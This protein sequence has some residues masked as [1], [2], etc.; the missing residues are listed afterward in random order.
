M[1]DFLVVGKGLMGAAAARYL[2][3]HSA[4]VA[5]M[6]PD[7]PVNHATHTGIFG[8]HY[9][10]AR[11]ISQ[12][13]NREL[14]WAALSHQ[15]VTQL[16]RLEVALGETIHRPVGCLSVLPAGFGA[17][18]LH[19]ADQLAAQFNASYTLLDG[20]QQRAALPML[21]FPAHAMALWEQAP[22]GYLNPRKLL[23]GQLA[24]AEQQQA[25]LIREIV[26]AVLDRGDHVEVR[27]EAGGS[28]QA[29]KVLIATGAFT[30][31]FN[32]FPK[33]LAL[34]TK[35]EFVVM[36]QVPR[37]EVERLQGMPAVSYQIEAENL[38]DLYLFPP[39]QYPDGNY[40]IKMGANTR[41]DRYVTTLDEINGWYRN[42]DSDEML[43]EMRT[44]LCAIVPGL[45]ATAWHTAR[46]VITRT[47]HAKPY[48]DVVV[49][50]RIYAAIGGNG[51]SAQ[52]SDGIGKVAAN[53][54]LH[55]AWHSPLEA[56][57]FRLVYAD[58]NAA[59]ANREL[60][61]GR[62]R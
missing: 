45:Q 4:Q 59:W 20:A 2:S 38:A 40:Y 16:P 37:E 43:A 48:I 1:Y 52:A 58:E 34:R 11:M 39:V 6:G 51:T 42:G 27:T 31:C 17:E 46:C 36:G 32:L 47:V 15:T 50:G 7:E 12:V 61:R 54:V 35:I 10:Q 60:A 57:A 26:T 8:A 9:D 23:A 3:E 56:N 22:A 13:I 44:A 29:R 62:M 24:V 25:T 5:V 21:A 33:P 30:N 14:I 53:L 41:A 28:Y 18:R 55:D 19:H 49:P